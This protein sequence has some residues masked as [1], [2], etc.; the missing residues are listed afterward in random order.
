MVRDPLQP[1]PVALGH[2]RVTDLSVNPGVA[3]NRMQLR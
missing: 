3:V 2:D 1:H